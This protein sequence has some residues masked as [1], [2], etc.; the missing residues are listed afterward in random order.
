[1]ALLGAGA[2]PYVETASFFKVRELSLSYTLPS[3]LVG[4][5]FTGRISS[6]RLSLDA[7]NL[8]AIFNYHGLD[9]EVSAFGNQALG[10]GYDVTPYPPS[11][12]YFLGL[13]L[14]L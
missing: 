10:R 8:F 11:Q 3:R 5:V 12:S 1:L 9:P 4:S 6:A 7:Y 14:V 13:D 2:E